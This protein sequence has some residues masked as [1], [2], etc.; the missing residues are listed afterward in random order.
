MPESP[1]LLARHAPS[2]SL[3]RGDVVRIETWFHPDGRIGAAR[4]WVMRNAETGE[5]FGRSTR[6]AGSTALL[7]KR[8]DT[9][10]RVVSLGNRDCS[11]HEDCDETSCAVLRVHNGR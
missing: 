3:L 6:Y 11:F 9:H 5:V 4:N 10:Q 1:L 2:V 8:A 7:L